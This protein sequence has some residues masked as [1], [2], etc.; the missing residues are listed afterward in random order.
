[1][2]FFQVYSKLNNYSLKIYEWTI[3]KKKLKCWS[4]STCFRSGRRQAKGKQ[5]QDLFSSSAESGNLGSAESGSWDGQ[6]LD[7]Q[8][9]I[10]CKIGG[11]G[12]PI[13][14][15]MRPPL[16]GLRN[17]FGR[18]RCFLQAGCQFQ[19]RIWTHCMHWRPEQKKKHEIGL[20]EQ[21]VPIERRANLF[22]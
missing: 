6:L 15:F 7:T 18:E 20:L 22:S 11:L 21:N 12:T 14:R 8:P 3:L 16:G 9:H 17:W 10:L 5:W 13:K 1:M 4:T 19:F 2:F